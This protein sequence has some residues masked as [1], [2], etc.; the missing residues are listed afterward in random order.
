MLA[1]LLACRHPKK[2]LDKE[3]SR[4]AARPFSRT[5]SLYASIFMFASISRSSSRV[6]NSYVC[7]SCLDALHAQSSA[8]RTSLH[9][10]IPTLRIQSAAFSSTTLLRSTSNNKGIISSY[11]IK[12]A[13]LKQDDGFINDLETMSEEDLGRKLQE[14]DILI[15]RRANYVS[16]EVYTALVAALP[17]TLK[18]GLD[19][20]YSLV[21]MRKLKERITQAALV[22][23]ASGNDTAVSRRAGVM[24][25]LVNNEIFYFIK[26]WIY[27]DGRGATNTMQDEAIK[28]IENIKTLAN[29]QNQQETTASSKLRKQGAATMRATAFM[30]ALKQKS[31]IEVDILTNIELQDKI[32]VIEEGMT[33]E[34]LEK[35]D[36]PADLVSKLS[37]VFGNS[38]HPSPLSPR[39]RMRSRREQNRTPA[40]SLT[41]DQPSELG[42]LG[43]SLI[44]GDAPSNTSNDQPATESSKNS[45]D[46]LSG[47]PVSKKKKSL[48]KPQSLATA[49]EVKSKT[50]SKW[51]PETA[52]EFL[53]QLVNKPFTFSISFSNLS[54]D[55]KAADS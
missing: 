27:G 1:Y 52:V 43:E 25:G 55:G 16:R 20:A 39:E 30:V 40:E 10:I 18:D 46:P 17:A 47:I 31:P 44:D 19:P 53:S 54:P 38:S 37:R 49:T 42:A 33:P 21:G 41:E 28:L 7:S 15:S 48:R 26:K 4:S 5:T 32:T 12:E 9:H 14:L 35:R 50:S 23:N 2:S 11:V 13:L 29:G 36:L 34:N 22:T 51:K 6:R 8:R 24:E 3:N 45:G